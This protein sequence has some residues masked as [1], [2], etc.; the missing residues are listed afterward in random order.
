MNFLMIKRLIFAGMLLLGIAGCSYNFDQYSVDLDHLDKHKL[1]RGYFM[2]DNNTIKVIFDLSSDENITFYAYIKRPFDVSRKDLSLL[3]IYHEYA[4]K[5]LDKE[6]ISFYRLDENKDMM[7]ELPRK[8]GTEYVRL[9]R[10]KGINYRAVC[11][12]DQAECLRFLESIQVNDSFW[13]HVADKVPAIKQNDKNNN[14]DFSLLSIKN[15]V[16]F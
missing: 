8:K 13:E 4:A 15:N 3:E 6:K 11:A 7:F 10:D 1:Y 14:S 2:D 12:Y 16:Y 5:S 9:F